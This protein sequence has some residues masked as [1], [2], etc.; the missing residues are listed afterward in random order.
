MVT[1]TDVFSPIIVAAAAAKTSMEM[2]PEL[3]ELE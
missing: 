1:V 3:P 2:S